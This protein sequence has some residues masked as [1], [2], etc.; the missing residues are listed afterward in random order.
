MKFTNQYNINIRSRNKYAIKKLMIK[1]ASKG[2]YNSIKINNIDCTSN[3][4]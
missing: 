3:N 2:K 4:K 1:I